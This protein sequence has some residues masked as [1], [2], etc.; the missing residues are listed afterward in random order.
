M[1]IALRHHEQ[2]LQSPLP[3]WWATPP[4]L[5]ERKSP[6]YSRKFLETNSHNGMV[7]LT[8]RLMS[9]LQ[10]L[11]PSRKHRYDTRETLALALIL[12]SG[13]SGSSRLLAC[14]GATFGEALE[15]SGQKPVTFVWIGRATNWGT[16]LVGMLPAVAEHSRF[17][18]RVPDMTTR[19]VQ[20][21]DL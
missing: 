9:S 4:T 19:V 16:N 10:T 1:V 18:K 12:A 21:V 20:V 15:R 2:F 5:A 11:Y 3:D 8:R 6:A 13:C 17:I 14:E 7:S